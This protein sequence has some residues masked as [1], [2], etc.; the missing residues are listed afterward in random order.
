MWLEVNTQGDIVGAHSAKSTSEHTWVEYEEE[1]VNPGDKWIDNR[2]VRMD[3]RGTGQS[4][5]RQAALHVDRTLPLQ[6][7][8]HIL[9]RGDPDDLARMNSFLDRVSAWCDEK[10]ACTK[11]LRNITL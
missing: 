10:V 7:Q 9:R 4:A 6:A 3:D 1:N 8:V 2:L 5:E 11:S